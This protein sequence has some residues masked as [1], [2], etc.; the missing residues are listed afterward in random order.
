MKRL[1]RFILKSFVGPFLGVALSLA[2]TMYTSTGIT[3]TLMSLV[4]VLIL[5]PS[6]LLFNTKIT[7]LEVVGAIISVAGVALFFL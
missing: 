5:W 2:S 1:D 6:H 7:P 3:Q 4:P